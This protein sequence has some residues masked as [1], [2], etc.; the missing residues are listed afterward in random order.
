MVLAEKQ[1]IYVERSKVN[2]KEETMFFSIG[3]LEGT[4]QTLLLTFSV[5]N[6]K[7]RLIINFNSKEIFNRELPEGT[8]SP[9]T[10]P[11]QNIQLNNELKFY[12]SDVGLAFWA[13]N[14]YELTDVKLLGTVKNTEAQRATTSFI[15]SQQEMENFDTA[16]LRYITE[17]SGDVGVLKIYMNNDLLTSKAPTCMAREKLDLTKSNLASGANELRFEL[18]R[19]SVYLT[20]LGLNLQ[21]KEP[22]WP[23]YYFEINQTVYDKIQNSKYNT[24]LR[25]K[26]IEDSKAKEA[27]I[28][29]NGRKLIM[30]EDTNFYEKNIEG[31]LIK[32]N[33]YI[34]LIPQTD[35]E[36]ATLRIAIV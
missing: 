9:I 7:G 34:K 25:I 32:G 4:P 2:K 31:Y 16:Y 18:S 35:L 26:F 6:A 29:I 30:E 22:R 13:T 10:I 1:S 21:V 19:G 17:C 24:M 28:N 8:A 14:R 11:V 23:A 15:I 33:N 36:I 5:E 27:E 20:N 3:N 12:T